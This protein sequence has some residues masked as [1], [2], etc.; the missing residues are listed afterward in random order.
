MEFDLEN[1]I[2]LYKTGEKWSSSEY[3]EK[4]M[5]KFQRPTDSTFY[6][7]LAKTLRAS[8]Y[9]YLIKTCAFHLSI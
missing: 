7:I 8:L 5:Q 6:D 3:I 9:Y 1:N 2:Y 4:N